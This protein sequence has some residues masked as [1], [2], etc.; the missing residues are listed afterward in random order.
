MSFFRSQRT[1]REPEVEAGLTDAEIARL[2]ALLA[3]S[4][5]IVPLDRVTVGGAIR[6]EEPC[7]SRG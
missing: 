6:D 7:G 2:L 5:D 1:S 3:P 4:V